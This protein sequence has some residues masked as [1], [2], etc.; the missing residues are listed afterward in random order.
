MKKIIKQA[1]DQGYEIKLGKNGDFYYICIGS[2][3][4]INIEDFSEMEDTILEVLIYE[5]NL[6]K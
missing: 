3:W 1:I 2:N 5:C 4:R 6:D